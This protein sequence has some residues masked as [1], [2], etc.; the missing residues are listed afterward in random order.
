MTSLRRHRNSTR[1][2]QKVV[3]HLGLAA[4]SLKCPYLQAPLIVG[5]SALQRAE[6]GH[7]VG[8]FRS[9]RQRMLS[10][11]ASSRSHHTHR[12]PCVRGCICKKSP[13]CGCSPSRWQPQHWKQ[14]P[15]ISRS[16]LRS[17]SRSDATHDH[18]LCFHWPTRGGRGQSV[19]STPCYCQTP[20]RWSKPRRRICTQ[21]GTVRTHARYL[22]A[23]SQAGSKCSRNATKDTARVF[24]SSSRCICV[25]GSPSTATSSCTPSLG[26]SFARGWMPSCRPA[27]PRASARA[28]SRTS[29]KECLGEDNSTAVSHSLL[30]RCCGHGD[31]THREWHRCLKP[32]C[33]EMIS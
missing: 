1:R 12:L 32:R 13:W 20:S 7:V 3:R 18:W 22:L 25:G 17:S 6:L 30:A 15:A 16:K 21:R 8:L 4:D 23:T 9:P 27:R 5:H 33:A 24:W 2:L 19:S 11:C 14:C 31:C 28:P 29:P 26:S 10:F